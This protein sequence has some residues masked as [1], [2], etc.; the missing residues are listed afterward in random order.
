[1]KHPLFFALIFGVLAGCQSIPQRVNISPFDKNYRTAQTN[2]TPRWGFINT[3]GQRVIGSRFDSVGPFLQGRAWVEIRNRYTYINTDGDPVFQQTFDEA[4]NYSEGL[5]P[6]RE[7]RQWG[8]IDLKGDWVIPP[9]FDQAQPF[10]GGLAAVGR[11]YQFGFIDAGG[12]TVISLQYSA[13][14][15]FKEG[16]AAVQW[17]NQWGYIDVKGKIV[18][19]AQFDTADSFVEGV[20][21]VRKNGVFQFIQ[22]DGSLA[23]GLDNPKQAENFSE[24][25]SAVLRPNG[26]FFMDRKGNYVV[27]QAMRF[28]TSFSEGLAAVVQEDA[29]R[30]GGPFGERP[31]TFRWEDP[32]SAGGSSGREARWGYINTY[33]TLV[34]A[35]TFQEAAPFQDQRGRVL[36]DG[37]YGFIDRTGGWIVTPQYDRAE[38]FS[39]G[40]AAVLWV[41]P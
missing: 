10:S 16:L 22:R 15:P 25:L 41:Q 7:G 11:Q 2:S 5:A 26:W 24:G 37:K 28:A 9:R 31:P 1:M 32:P 8:Y 12:D 14:K 33:G 27:R 4:R 23:M 35:S 29:A 34:I 40:L 30:S 20:A 3:H 39:E 6:V 38:N 21:R 36:S 13:V 19:Q 18:I 17:N